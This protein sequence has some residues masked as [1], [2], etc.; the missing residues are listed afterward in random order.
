MEFE[1]AK[2]FILDRLNALSDR[3]TYHKKQ[4]TLDVMASA[5]VI[6]AA[7][8]LNKETTHLLKIAC[9]MHDTGFLEKYQGHEDL[10][11]EYAKAWL[12]QFEYTTEQIERIRGMILATKIPHKPKNL[13][14][15]IICDADLDYLGT[16]DYDEIS[17]KLYQE[18]KCYGFVNSVN[19]WLDRQIAFLKL[20]QYFS[21]Y[22][23]NN[24]L[25][26][27]KET[28]QRLQLRKESSSF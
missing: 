16:D 21:D 27:K 25:A 24:R 7:E 3:L 13:E 22:S 28:L 23:I 2:A 26:K 4:Q 1:L 5:E 17:E 8:G 12:P 18:W 19:D 11:A 15:Q 6:A 9:L 20:H 10:S 14:E